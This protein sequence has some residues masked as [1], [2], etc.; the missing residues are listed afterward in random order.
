MHIDQK[1]W[2]RGLIVM[3]MAFAL[4]YLF[5]SVPLTPPDE[6]AHILYP[7]EILV[8]HHLPVLTRTSDGWENHQPPLYYLVSLPIVWASSH[9]A[10]HNQVTIDRFTSWLLLM[11]AMWGMWR[12]ARR[13]WPNNIVSRLAMLSVVG[14]SMVL[15][16]G[17]SFNNDILGLTISSWL[18]YLVVAKPTRLSW[19]F[20][21]ALGVCIGAGM[22]TKVNLYPLIA[23]MGLWILWRQSWKW[24]LT[25]AAIALAISGWW[26]IHNL[27]QVGDILG[28]KHAADFFRAQRQSLAS[29]ATLQ[30]LAVKTAASF[31][32]LFEKLNVRLPLVWYGVILVVIVAAMAFAVRRVH[33]SMMWMVV[34]ATVAM[35]GGFLWLNTTI[36][37]PQGRYL[38]ALIPLLGYVFG[39][40]I[41]TIPRR[42]PTV[43]AG[44]LIVLIGVN[45]SGLMALRAYDKLH[46]VE[47][48]T[49]PRTVDSAAE[50]NQLRPLLLPQVGQ[51]YIVRSPMKIVVSGDVLE[52]GRRP[53]LNIMTDEQQPFQVQVEWRI[54]GQRWF[55]ASRTLTTTVNGSSSIRIP[56]TTATALIN[57]RLTFLDQGRE[58]HLQAL[59]LQGG[60]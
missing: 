29:L 11:L 59:T 39:V 26:Y 6:Q 24:W 28:L 34:V 4:A 14:L 37:Q 18:F 56:E 45:I 20:S 22:L 55:D 15:Y 54:A 30:T 38:I 32:G 57:V 51:E 7:R 12:M 35:Y 53:T 10:F 3:W 27:T 46:P 43:V 60:E 13:L 31:V 23:V 48:W 36:F 16:A 52:S 8:E 19:R 25:V 41:D 21:V 47:I 40:A 17:G 1:W 49:Y 9:I 58:I 50:Y 2:E 42:R 44:W 33:S 5:V